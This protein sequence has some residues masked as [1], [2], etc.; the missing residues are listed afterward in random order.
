MRILLFILFSI[1][2]ISCSNNQNGVIVTFDDEKSNAIRAHYQNYLKNNIEGL[3][4]LWSPDL[5]IYMNSVDPSGVDEISELITTQHENFDNISL[6][7]QDEGATEDL[8]VWAQTIVYPPMNGNAEMTITQTWFNWSAT[9]KASGNTIEIPVHIS[10][11]WS[12]GKIVREW[13]NFD[14]TEMMA[15]LELAASQSSE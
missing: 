1:F 14:T 7:F 8:G 15:E 2:T 6:S 9:G 5:R 13:H 10:F 3:K 12:D 4:S 11:E